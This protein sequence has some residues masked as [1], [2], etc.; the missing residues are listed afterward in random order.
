MAF[1]QGVAF[2]ATLAFVTDGAN[3]DAELDP[4]AGVTYP[5]TTAQGNTVGWET[6]VGTGVQ[7]RNRNAGNDPRLAGA[8]WSDSVGT[9]DFRID[10][11]AAGGYNIRAAMGE[12]NYAR[13]VNCE[14]RDG[15]TVLATLTSGATSAAQRFKDATNVERTNA[16]W[17]GSNAAY[18]A[19]FSGTICR[20]R[21]STATDSV[22]PVAYFYVEAIPG[23]SIFQQPAGA[24]INDGDYW[25]GWIV[26]DGT[27]TGYQWQQNTGSG[28][29]DVVGQTTRYFTA[30]TILHVAD[31]GIQYRCVVTNAGG[32]TISSAA[33]VT[34]QAPRSGRLGEW[35]RS[36]DVK[37]WW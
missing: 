37:G 16:T 10:L 33:G 15:T 11:P 23:P 21:T 20:L 18:A 5:R 36:L 22:N 17:P 6:V 9:M 14:L 4:S 8:H 24:T 32:T 31:S 28:W 12:P 2:R 1:P 13:N 34:V 27:A 30:A 26:D 29:T 19:T 35:D 25:Y 3:D 7:S